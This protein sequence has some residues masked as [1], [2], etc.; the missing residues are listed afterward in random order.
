MH[1]KCS[2]SRK[3][4]LATVCVEANEMQRKKKKKKSYD[5]DEADYYKC[6]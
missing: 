2:H 1:Q 5:F 6:I 3:V 4:V